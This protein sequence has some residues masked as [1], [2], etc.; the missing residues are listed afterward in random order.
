MISFYEAK[1]PGEINAAYEKFCG[2][3]LPILSFN[4]K[5]LALSGAFNKLA[6]T[7]PGYRTVSGICKAAAGT[8]MSPEQEK[9]VFMLLFAL[10]RRKES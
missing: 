1:L 7:Q 2:P 10:N 3:L 8:N 6:K 4:D 9:G 5:L